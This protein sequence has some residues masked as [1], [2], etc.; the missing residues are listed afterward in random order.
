MWVMR[1]LLDADVSNVLF[2]VF[3]RLAQDH[4]VFGIRFATFKLSS[5]L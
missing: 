5:F 2:Q 4:L 3:V 1:L